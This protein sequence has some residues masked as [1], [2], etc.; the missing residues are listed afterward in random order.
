MDSSKALKEL[1]MPQT[2]LRETIRKTVKWYKENGYW[3]KQ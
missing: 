2:P 3:S 1:G